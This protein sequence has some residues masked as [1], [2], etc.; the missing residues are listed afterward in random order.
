LIEAF[1]ADGGRESGYMEEAGRTSVER[2]DSGWKRRRD[3]MLA[4]PALVADVRMRIGRRVCPEIH[5]AF[6]F[7]ASRT[8]RDVVAAY[9]AETGG[10]FD[11]HRDNVGVLVEHRRFALSIP[12]ND[13]FEG[14][15]LAFPEFGWRDGRPEPRSFSRAPSFTSFPA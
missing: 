9:D 5:K 3:L 4:D 11:Q 12:L 6:Q 13:D 7:R 15:E 2:L 1:D 14:G 8:E 10:H